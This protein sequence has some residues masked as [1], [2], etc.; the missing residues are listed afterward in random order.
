[1]KTLLCV[2]MVLGTAASTF[3]GDCSS[4]QCH[5]PVRTVVKQTTRIV[6]SPFRVTRQFV[7]NSRYRRSCNNCR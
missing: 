3:A 5:R 4:G 7:N 2:I 1:M 6:T